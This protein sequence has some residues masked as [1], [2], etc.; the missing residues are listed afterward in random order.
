MGKGYKQTAHIS[1]N[2]YTHTH[3]HT[4]TLT[5]RQ[6]GALTDKAEKYQS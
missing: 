2:T 1:T 3:T 6:K 5:K 4:H